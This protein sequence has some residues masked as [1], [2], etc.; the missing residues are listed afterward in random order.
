MDLQCMLA[1]TSSLRRRSF[2]LTVVLFVIA[3]L[4]RL[5]S[6][7]RY[8]TPDEPIWVLRSIRFAEALARGDWQA[9]PQ[10]G[11]PGFTTMTLGALGIRLA[12]WLQP[13]EAATHLDWLRNVAWLTPENDVAF[14]YLAYFLPAGRLLVALVTALGVSVSYVIARNRIGERGARLL[15]LF[16][17]LD[18]FLAGHGALLH[19]DALQATFAGLAAL[20]ALPPAT[21]SDARRRIFT[22]ELGGA[23][24]CIALAGLTKSLGLLI[25]PGIA[26]TLLFLEERPWLQRVA[27]VSVLTALALAFYSAL[28]LPVW[29]EPKSAVQTLYQALTRH[30]GFGA[31]AVRF[32]G[33][34]TMDPGPLFY[35]LTLFFRL[36]PAVLVGLGLAIGGALY[37]RRA[38]A[39][40][41]CWLVL[42]ALSYLI[43]IT[44]PQKKFA[45]YALTLIPLLTTVAALAWAQQPR[46]RRKIIV[47]TLLCAWAL[48]APLPLYSADPLVGGPWL[49]QHLVPLG[50]GESAGLAARYADEHLPSP[51]DATL[52]T[53]NVPGAAPFFQGITRSWDE[54]VLD[55]ADAFIADAPPVNMPETFAPAKTFRLAG[56]GL[57]TVYTQT[58]SL[59]AQGP[60]PVVSAHAFPQSDVVQTPPLTDT[61]GVHTWAAERLLPGTTF[62]WLATERCAPLIG[63]QLK[64]VLTPGVTCAPRMSGAAARTCTVTTLLPPVPAYQ[65]RFGEG[66]MLDTAAL[67]WSVSASEPLIL[68]LRWRTQYPQNALS[69]YATLRAGNHDVVWSESGGQLVDDRTWSTT[70]WSPGALIDGEV[71][72]VLPA[73]LPPGVYTP[74]LSLIDEENRRLGLWYAEGTFGGTTFSLAPVEIAPSPVPAE[75]PPEITT[76]MD[77][78]FPG[79]RLLGA[80]SLPNTVWAGDTLPFQL[81]WERLSGAPDA[82]LRW[83]L[84]CEGEEAAGTLALAPASPRAWTE[85]YHYVTRYAPRIDPLFSSDTCTLSVAPGKATP[86]VIGE[87]TLQARARQFTLETKPSRSLSV[88]VGDFATLMGVDAPERLTPG[89]TFTTTLYWQAQAPATL[90]YSVFVHLVGPEEQ[91]WA[92][93]DALPQGGVSP[94]RSW[95]TGQ[96]IVDRHTLTLPPEAPAGR[97]TLLAGL[98]NVETGGRVPLY[99]DD[100][101]PLPDNRAV[102]ATPDLHSKDP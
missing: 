12:T 3:L 22:L 5:V 14:D 25:A 46:R 64:T 42:P 101:L 50:W 86:V 94:T 82:T 40:K 20:L 79:L 45:R 70:A 76:E 2:W 11:H 15:G 24:L 73:H 92:Q 75:R 7:G 23:A 26:L 100:V 56:L 33:R 62:T 87:V 16:L 38:I 19:T 10:T 28:Y 27:R 35:P 30:Q 97:Y 6:L 65:A 80:A 29:H 89:M 21:H 72:M 63:Q 68:R 71:P 51:A 90:D 8:V 85:G 44:L 43:G 57:A 54:R 91:I 32:A 77:V 88:T 81:F 96:Y 4:L 1:R 49:A 48:V 95:V 98:Y 53:F 17:A 58:R 60:A 34:M 59:F 52:L 74:T 78:A 47:T 41:A 69:Y 39:R 67:P 18:P 36:S 83:S 55:C 93:S 84:Q 102:I 99:A 61:Q 37:R 31:R 13:A 9:L 66:L